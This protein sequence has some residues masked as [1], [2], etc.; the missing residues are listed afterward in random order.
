MN[1][2]KF[3]SWIQIRLQ[4]D[5]THWESPAIRKARDSR[6]RAQSGEGALHVKDYNQVIL[7]SKVSSTGEGLPALKY[8][9][10][11]KRMNVSR[12]LPFPLNTMQFV[13]LS[14]RAVGHVGVVSPFVFFPCSQFKWSLSVMIITV[15][16]FYAN[17]S[18]FCRHATLIKVKYAVTQPIFNVFGATVIACIFIRSSYSLLWATKYRQILR[19]G[20]NQNTRNNDNMLSFAQQNTYRYVKKPK[21]RLRDP[22]L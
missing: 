8:G 9:C 6:D 11:D 21:D 14:K 5:F 12:L 2:K 17:T 15:T 10:R 7:I 4:Q 3:L 13:N 22:A 18:M 20:G 16:F 1:R 19:V